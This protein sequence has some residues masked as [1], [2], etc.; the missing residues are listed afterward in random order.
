MLIATVLIIVTNIATNH[1]TVHEGGWRHKAA[2]LQNSNELP[3][4]PWFSGSVFGGKSQIVEVT[5]T[6]RPRM[7]ICKAHRTVT[8]IVSAKGT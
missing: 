2:A 5:Q 1:L 7:Y 6:R 8:Y 3:T 4:S